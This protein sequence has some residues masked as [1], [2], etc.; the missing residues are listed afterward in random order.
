[1]VASFVWLLVAT[2]FVQVPNLL[3]IHDRQQDG[4]LDIWTAAK[5]AVLTIPLTFIATTGFTLYYGRAEQHFS[6]PAMVIYAHIAALI[7]G[8]VIQVGIL[9]SKETNLLEIAGLLICMFGLVLSIYS[10][11]IL[12]WLKNI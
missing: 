3:G 2:I 11:P 7:I 8:I 6:Y 4:V 1:M 10:K 5:I 12:A 9:K